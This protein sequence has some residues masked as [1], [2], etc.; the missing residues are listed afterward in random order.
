MPPDGRVVVA[1]AHL[2]RTKG[3]D[4]LLKA[5]AKLPMDTKLVIIGG[6]PDGGVYK[7]HLLETI[8]RLGLKERV[9]LAG[10]QHHDRI[11]LYLN[12]ADVSVLAS[13]REG[14]PNV[15]LESLACGTPVVVSD[16]GSVRDMFSSRADV[17]IV[18]TGD[19]VALADGISTF[20]AY[21]KRAAFLRDDAVKSWDDVAR[22]MLDI[23]TTALADR[24]ILDGKGER[25][26]HLNN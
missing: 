26:Q 22:D 9:I 7:Q 10:R 18:P 24:R 19:I 12:A 2:K 13:H 20:L 6:S 4:D 17:R 14:C 25:S 1:I 23:F 8:Q 15:V 11:P 16:V 5:F 21:A 3:H